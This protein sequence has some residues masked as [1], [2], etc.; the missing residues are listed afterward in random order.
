VFAAIEHE[1]TDLG[2]FHQ[3]Q[4]ILLVGLGVIFSVI[5]ETGTSSGGCEMLANAAVDI[6]FEIWYH[7]FGLGGKRQ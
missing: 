3:V 7:C 2:G 5:V 1:R 6:G 4:E